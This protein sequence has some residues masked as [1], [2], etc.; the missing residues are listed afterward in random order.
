MP[1]G[2]FAIE[3]IKEGKAP[4]AAQ[5]MLQK[6]RPAVIGKQN[7]M[8]VGKMYLNSL[9]G[10]QIQST[11]QFGDCRTQAPTDIQGR[12]RN[13]NCKGWAVH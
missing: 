3:L 8:K 5:T 13:L 2:I 6:A 10:S 12:I 9:G 7:R 4:S 1:Y 11:F